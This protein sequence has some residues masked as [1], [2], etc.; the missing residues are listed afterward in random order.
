MN[1]FTL[2]TEYWR[3]I[4][5][6]KIK[7]YLQAGEIAQQRKVLAMQAWE[8]AFHPQ[9]NERT[10]PKFSSDFYMHAVDTHICI[11]NNK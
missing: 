9:W 8:P 4:L 3:G 5:H 11:N 6:I 1:S 10:S 2:S 7:T